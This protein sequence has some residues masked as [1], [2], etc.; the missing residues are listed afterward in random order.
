MMCDEINMEQCLK[1]VEQLVGSITPSN[2]AVLRRRPYPV[3]VWLSNDVL[4]KSLRSGQC[5]WP[6]HDFH[7]QII[8]FRSPLFLLYVAMGV[9]VS[10]KLFYSSVLS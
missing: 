10:N 9:S 1:L 3:L 4:G 2:E 5:I 8:Q 7:K 6:S